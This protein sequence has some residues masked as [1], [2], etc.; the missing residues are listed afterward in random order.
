[1]NRNP[2]VSVIVTTYN[3]KELLKETIDSIT[4]QTFENFELIVIDNFS[5]YDLFKYVE[6]FKDSRIRPYQNRNDGIIAINRNYGIRKAKGKYIAFCDDDDCWLPHKL[7]TQ[8]NKLLHSKN[9]MIFSMHKKFGDISIFSNNYG[10]NPLPFRVNTSP[11]AL[12]RTNCI[13]LST[14]LI[15]KDSL[16]KIGLFDERKSFIAI[17]DNEIW[18]RASKK[19][20]IDFIPEILVLHRVHNYSIYND[21]K[22]IN[23]GKKEIWSIHGNSSELETISGMKQNVFYFYFRNLFKLIYEILFFSSTYVKENKL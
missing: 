2:L 21:A 16:Y 20:E 7:E 6:S 5:D 22:N 9:S 13:P 23:E 15:E 10:I 11:E 1:M 12:L 19:L 8:I 3:R 17:E 18:I 14:V 4:N